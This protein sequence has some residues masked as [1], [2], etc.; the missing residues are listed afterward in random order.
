VHSGARL[1]LG[2]YDF[3]GTKVIFA[4]AFDS[5]RGEGCL[6]FVWADG[7][8]YCTPS[9]GD[10]VYEDAACTIAMGRHYAG[11]CDAPSPVSYFSS[12]YLVRLDHIRDSPDG[13]ARGGIARRHRGQVP[14]RRSRTC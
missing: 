7:N 14:M 9:V 13:G 3:G 11:E 5:Q 12:D 2:W 4:G 1:K 10:I 8:T 6:P